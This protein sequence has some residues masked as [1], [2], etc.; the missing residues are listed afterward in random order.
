MFEHLLDRM[1]DLSPGGPAERL[2]SNFINWIKHLPVS[3]TP[4]AQARLR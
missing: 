1:P 3:F 2:Q 4:G